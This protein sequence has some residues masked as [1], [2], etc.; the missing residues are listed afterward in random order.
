MK[1]LGEGGGGAEP[2]EP[3]FK[4]FFCEKIFWGHVQMMFYYLSI[5]LNKHEHVILIN[6]RYLYIERK[7]YAWVYVQMFLNSRN[8][9]H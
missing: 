4:V 5:Y 9:V 6:N 8:Y 1:H 3:I 2:P 7:G